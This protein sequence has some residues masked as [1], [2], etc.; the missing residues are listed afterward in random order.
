AEYKYGQP[1][2]FEVLVATCFVWFANQGIDVAVIEAGLGGKFDGTNA[3]NATVCVVTNVGLDHTQILG[4]TKLKI[5]QDKMQVIKKGNAVAVT[6]VCQPELLEVLRKHCADVQVPLLVAEQDFKAEKAIANAQGSNFNYIFG[7]ETINEIEVKTPG[8]YQVANASVAITACLE[9]ARAQGMKLT[10][11]TIKKALSTTAFP[12]RFEIVRENPLLVLDGAHNPDKINALVAAWKAA[13]PGQRAVVVFGLKKN[14]NA[15]EM[16]EILEP[17]VGA[18]VVTQFN[19]AT[20]MGLNLHF[21]AEK[22]VRVAEKVLEVPVY[23]ESESKFAME[24]A[25]ELAG[26]MGVL[27]TGSLYLVGEVKTRKE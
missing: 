10:A 16:L 9:F 15:D 17:I 11:E 13:Y 18:M 22:L 25:E 6:G 2:Y 27:V 12:G 14:K 19:Q 20:D 4:D 8:L 5:L 7:T 24:K 26:E 23:L 21:P 1:S 3:L